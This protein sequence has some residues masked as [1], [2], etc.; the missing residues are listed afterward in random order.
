MKVSKKWSSV[1]RH[2]ALWEF[3]YESI[4]ANDP[5]PAGNNIV[6]FVQQTMINIGVQIVGGGQGGEREGE[7]VVRLLLMES[8]EK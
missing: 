1:V 8:L 5:Q 4:T 6:R 7:R 2:P 3:Y